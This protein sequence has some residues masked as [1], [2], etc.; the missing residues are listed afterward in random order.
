MAELTRVGAGHKKRRGPR[1]LLAHADARCSHITPTGAAKSVLSLSHTGATL[2]AAGTHTVGSRCR[3][4]VAYAAALAKPGGAALI[5]PRVVADAVGAA[6]AA[7]ARRRRLSGSAHAAAA[8]A[9]TDGDDRGEAHQ[10]H[11]QRMR[12][13]DELA[14][15]V[16]QQ[17]EVGVVRR[18][19]DRRHRVAQ[20]IGQSANPWSP[21]IAV[22]GKIVAAVAAA[23][24]V[25]GNRQ[26]RRVGGGASAEAAAVGTGVGVGAA[27]GGGDG[28]AA[29]ASKPLQSARSVPSGPRWARRTAQSLSH[30][31][32]V[33]STASEV[34]RRRGRRRRRAVGVAAASVA[35]AR[36][37]PP[38]LPPHRRRRRLC[39]RRRRR[40]VASTAAAVPAG[41]DGGS[42]HR[43]PQWWR[44]RACRTACP[45]SRP[46]RGGEGRITGGSTAIP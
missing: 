26:T 27:A 23:A 18:P 13:R 43:R 44:R 42:C 6:G 30:A 19:L 2:R 21:A 9:A 20:V 29:S 16:G 5:S 12:P 8:A 32:S 1:A 45:R 25:V 11:E 3:R 37:P 33:R 36:P 31:L 17:R 40:R 34:A 10:R 41:G 22:A 24:A 15:A 4:R 14:L 46:L 35:T 39:P 7:D 28:D 38:P